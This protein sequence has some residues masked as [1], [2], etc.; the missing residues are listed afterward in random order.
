MM[1][2]NVFLRDSFASASENMLFDEEMFTK[3]QGLTHDPGSS[4]QRFFRFYSW[5]QPSVTYCHKRGLPCDFTDIDHSSRL[6]GGGLVFHS[7]G[8]LVFSCTSRIEDDFFPQKLKDKISVISRAVRN[9]FECFDIKLAA[10]PVNRLV[11]DIGF[12][13]TYHNPFELYDNNEKIVGLT[14]RKA[15]AAFLI[16]GIIH[17]Q[18]SP[19]IFFRLPEKYHKYLSKGLTEDNLHIEALTEQIFARLV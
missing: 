5:T 1:G 2:R 15:K 13:K 10:K 14:L 8:D 4:C 9:A 11:D 17:L 12:C 7:P 16:Q 18:K 3:A 6:T 19:E